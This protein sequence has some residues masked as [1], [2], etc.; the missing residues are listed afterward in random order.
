MK[1]TLAL[2]TLALLVSLSPQSGDAAVEEVISGLTQPVRLVAPEGDPRLFVV[3]RNGLIR[4]FDQMGVEQGTF[5]DLRDSTTTF[6]ERG[7]LGLVFAPD[8]ESSGRIYVNYTDLQGDTRIVRLTVSGSDP[9]LADMGTHEVILTVAQPE[10]NHNGGH[11]EF[12]SDGMLY[13]ALGDGGGAGDP[14]NSAQNDQVL[15]GKMLRL[16]VSGPTGYAV[17]GDNPFVGQA[18]LDEIWAIGLRNPWCFS[19]D[20]ATGDLY[21]ADVGQS[22]EEEIDIQ[23]VTSP[24]GENYGWR[25]MEGTL[26][27]IPSV[28]CNDG[29]LI[30]PAYTY[31]RGGS[32]FRCSISGGYVYRGTRMPSLTGQ[33]FYSD[34]CSNQIWSLTWTPAGGVGAVTERTGQMTPPGGYESVASFGQDGLGELYVLDL[35]SGKVYRII[36]A[37]SD[38]PG[39]FDGPLL[40]QNAPNPFNPRTGIAFSLKSNG[41]R[42]T[43]MVFDAAGHRVRTLVDDTLPAGDHLAHWDGTDD[44]GGRIPSGVYLYRLEVDGEVAS[45]KMLLLE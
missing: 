7:L 34:Y 9:D 43:L 23:P 8:Y 36:G 32:P 33:Y 3:Q 39:V 6:R 20:R 30:L 21:I 29:S 26:C 25:L 17:P 35:D 31:A 18:P 37:A 40:A 27:Y 44:A 13:A 22:N 14:D 41:S 15:L 12:G 11:L 19:F 5:L 42:V 45:R 4:I 2:A 1:L 38:V 16:D 24:G 28:N 10:A